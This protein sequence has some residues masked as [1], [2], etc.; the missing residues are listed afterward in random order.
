MVVLEVTAQHATQVP[1]I[2]HDH[3]VQAFSPYGTDQPFDVWILP[4]GSRR[5]ENFLYPQVL[6][7]TTEILPIDAVAIPQQIVWGAITGKRLHDLLRRPLRARITGDIEMQ[8]VPPVMGE[9]EQDE[10]CLLYTS[11]AADEEDSVDLGGRRIIKKKK[12]KIKYLYT[13]IIKI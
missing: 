2:Q 4:R 8:N 10:H 7:S 1:L 9:D 6:D 5:S 3:M 13:R 11:D 12:K